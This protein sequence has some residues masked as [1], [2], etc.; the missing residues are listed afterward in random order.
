MKRRLLSILIIVL[1]LLALISGCKKKEPEAPPEQP[2]EGPVAVDPVIEPDDG[3]DDGGFSIPEIITPVLS[4]PAFEEGMP[5]PQEAPFS[6]DDIF[7]FSTLFH[8]MRTVSGNVLT[9]QDSRTLTITRQGE[10]YLFSIDDGEDHIASFI[11]T[12]IDLPVAALMREGTIV[13][14]SRI[15]PAGSNIAQDIGSFFVQ[16]GEVIAWDAFDNQ[17][18]AVVS[19]VKADYREVAELYLFRADGSKVL[20]YSCPMVRGG[21]EEGLYSVAFD[22]EGN[23]YVYD[24]GAENPMS[25]WQGKTMIFETKNLPG[26]SWSVEI[27]GEPR[28][29]A[30]R[31]YV[32]LSRSLSGS[33]I[34]RA[35]FDSETKEL[36]LLASCEDMFAAYGQIMLSGEGNNDIYSITLGYETDR[37]EGAPPLSAA[38]DGGGTVMLTFGQNGFATRRFGLSGALRSNIWSYD[39]DY[40]KTENTYFTNI[41]WIDEKH[42]LYCVETVGRERHS[43]EIYTLAV[44]TDPLW[45][46]SFEGAGGGD[47]P[48][49]IIKF[50][51]VKNGIAMVT[52]ER[53]IFYDQNFNIVLERNI[54]TSADVFGNNLPWIVTDITY[55][56]SRLLYIQNGSLYIAAADFS[57]PVLIYES[58]WDIGDTSGMDSLGASTDAAFS[59]DEQWAAFKVLGYEWVV[60]LGIYNVERKDFTFYEGSMHFNWLKGDSSRLYL[61]GG[62][63]REGGMTPGVLDLGSGEITNYRDQWLGSI[64]W[65]NGDNILKFSY[66][67]KQAVISVTD[68]R[69]GLEKT[70]FEPFR[71]SA[72]PMGINPS[73]DGKYIAF[74]NEYFGRVSKLVIMRLWQ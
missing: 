34:D 70:N 10:E 7:E 5:K 37:I 69:S 51:P 48:E 43:Y 71:A 53:V 68:S 72:F 25:G 61:L 6:A 52:S 19:R 74:L 28:P 65:L 40:K 42:L 24:P 39:V 45:T 11:E 44:G 29:M 31:R 35:V 54:P 73:P 56:A 36:V 22:Q 49:Q 17:M 8:G 60:G 30:D 1:M 21:E 59:E 46:A 33:D 2:V 20:L 63:E 13:A 47:Y 38:F 62:D 15:L 26:E 16:G 58:T 66:G 55:D 18:A 9:F 12:E 64:G 50:I 32:G 3:E 23:L 57:D 67:L 4:D 27:L 14:G 41:T